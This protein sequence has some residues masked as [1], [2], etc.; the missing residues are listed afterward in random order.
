MWIDVTAY[1]IRV[2]GLSKKKE[3]MQAEV[4]DLLALGLSR[5]EI[6]EFFRG[7]NSP[8]RDKD[9]KPYNPRP[10]VKMIDGL[11]DAARESIQRLA[12]VDH[13][14]YIGQAL[15][16]LNELYK[17]CRLAGER[18]S[19]LAV[20]KEIHKLLR[21][22]PEALALSDQPV[23]GMKPRELRSVSE[24]LD[25]LDEFDALD[26]GGDKTYVELVKMI[27]MET[28][29]PLRL[30]ENSQVKIENDKSGVK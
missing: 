6:M 16:R 25:A 26:P 27:R 4:V 3:K 19:A 15:Y 8:Y 17:S 1:K 10:G 11:I 5:M 23:P 24:V 12:T 30:T 18:A 9:Q 21:L 14:A 22:Q 13:R 28:T 20:Q 2:Y 7:G 29:K